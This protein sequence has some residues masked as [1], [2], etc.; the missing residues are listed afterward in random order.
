MFDRVVSFHCTLVSST[1]LRCV[2]Y[3]MQICFALCAPLH[4]SMYSTA[5][6]HMYVCTYVHSVCTLFSHLLGAAVLR[7]LTTS[8]W[9]TI[10]K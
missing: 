10:C 6:L 9:L 3:Y 8:L 7:T 4:I 1:T 5:L 2:I